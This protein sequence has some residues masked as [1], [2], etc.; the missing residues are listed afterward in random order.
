L[1]LKN[2]FGLCERVLYLAMYSWFSA[3]ALIVLSG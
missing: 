3:V 2:R 1:T